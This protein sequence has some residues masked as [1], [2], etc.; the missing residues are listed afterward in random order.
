MTND[1]FPLP[2]EVDGPLPE[3]GPGFRQRVLTQVRK[4][5]GRRRVQRQLAGIALVAS[6]AAFGSMTLLHRSPHP[7]APTAA[8]SAHWNQELESDLTWLEE[9]E[10]RR[11]SAGETAET[12]SPDVSGARSLRYFFP[13]YQDLST[14]GR[15]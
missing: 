7:T 5:R 3:L 15:N 11:T 13:A 14:E 10:A 12:S 8:V 4:T 6:V 1:H 2:D 9:A